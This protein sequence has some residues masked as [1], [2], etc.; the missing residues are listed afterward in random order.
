MQGSFETPG[1]TSRGAVANTTYRPPFRGR[2]FAVSSTHYLATMAGFKI[3]ERSGNAVDA[4]VAAGIA[5][6][7]VEPHLTTFA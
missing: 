2:R 5:L 6:N 1:A 3:L 4:G 7:V